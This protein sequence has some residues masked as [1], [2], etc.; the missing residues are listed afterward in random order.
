MISVAVLLFVQLK[1]CCVSISSATDNGLCIYTNQDR[2][3]PSNIPNQHGKLCPTPQHNVIHIALC[4]SV[5]KLSKTSKQLLTCITIFICPNTIYIVLLQWKTMR[6]QPTSSCD[7]KC[8]AVVTRLWQCCYNKSLTLLERYTETKRDQ[9]NTEITQ[10]CLVI[11]T[12][13]LLG[14]LSYSNVLPPRDQK[15]HVTKWDLLML[16]TLSS[17]PTKIQPSYQIKAK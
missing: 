1:Y 10:T 12:A 14:S 3:R 16:T 4:C 6:M 2:N 7:I 8:F 5:C 11:A 15:I 13:I 9:K 17:L